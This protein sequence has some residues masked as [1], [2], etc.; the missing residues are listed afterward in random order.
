[1][2]ACLYC[3]GIK[4]IDITCPK[5]LTS[6]ED[7]GKVSDYYQ[8]YSPYREIDDLKMT[9]GF[10]DNLDQHKCIHYL[11]CPHCQFQQTISFQEE[12]I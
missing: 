6:V 11:S 10:P 1:M 3:N 12:I 7:L 2:Y 4:T 5:C 9:D 8:A